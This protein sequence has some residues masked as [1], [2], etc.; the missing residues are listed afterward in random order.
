MSKITLEIG[1]D[2][3]AYAMLDVP[4]G[5]AMEPDALRPLI[6][7]L[8]EDDRLDVNWDSSGATRIVCV[9]IRGESG[10]S[11]DG[12]AG[13]LLGHRFEP[14]FQDAGY[15]LRDF[16]HG[17]ISLARLVSD[18]AAYGLIPSAG[19][20]GADGNVPSER[21]PVMGVRTG[22]LTI[23]ESTL[24]TQIQ[25]RED[26]TDAELRLALSDALGAVFSFSTA[27]EW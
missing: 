1:V 22:M 23:G 13:R 15:S 8:I 20:R 27:Q 16:L 7:K 10:Q 19:W 21:T 5:Y 25:V 26:A 3:S 4:A 6:D 18:A 14:S 12:D 11:M 2:V 9:R 17:K 24:S